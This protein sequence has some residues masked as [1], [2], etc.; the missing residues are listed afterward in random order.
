MKRKNQGRRQFA[1]MSTHH[2][3][4]KKLSL[5]AKGL[6]S[7]MLSLPEN[8]KFSCKGLASLSLD[9]VDGVE[10]T[11]AELETK[12]YLR[13]YQVR[14]EK[15]QFLKYEYEVYEVPVV[16]PE[17]DKTDGTTNQFKDEALLGNEECPVRPDAREPM[18]DGP[19]VECPET[20]G[21]ALS[22]NKKTSIQASNIN[23]SLSK[24]RVEKR[25]AP[26]TLDEVTS[27]IRECNSSVSPQRFHAYYTARGWKGIV[28]WRALV[29]SWEGMN[30]SEDTKQQYQNGPARRGSFDTDGFFEAAIR[31]S[32]ESAENDE[33]IDK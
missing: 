10:T 24:E 4:D 8:W 28:D 15:G 20:G 14:N 23:A 18:T 16:P 12:G 27:Y 7:I 25:N 21:T 19:L 33:P 30:F 29:M 11:L 26:P 1:N 2:L 9:G 22:K 31:R 3:R 13:R 5:K 32:L 6:Q 17:N